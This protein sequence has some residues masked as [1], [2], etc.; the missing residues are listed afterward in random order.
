MITPATIQKRRELALF[1]EAVLAPDP[2]V[3]GVVGIGSIASGLCRPDSDIDAL[4]F[5][6]PF[7]WYVVPAEFK[8]RPSDGSFHSIFSAD[9]AGCIDFDLARCDLAAWSDPAFAWPEGRRA[10][11]ASGW[12]AFDRAGRIAELIADRAAY[13]AALRTARLDEAITWLD[14]HLGE[15]GPQ[16]RWASLGPLIAHDRLQAAYEYLVQ[17]LFAYNRR[18]RAWRNRELPA[19]LELPWLPERFAERLAEAALAPGPDHAGYMRRAAALSG[20]FDDLAGQLHA[21]G[22]YGADVIGEAFIRSHQEPGRAWNMDEW[23]ARH[24]SRRTENP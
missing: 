20:L 19:L 3:Q 23:N 16:V 10:E 17:A 7:D 11:I 12:L 18:W 9:A 22:E 4:V 2:A 24:R 5:L 21:D 15:D 1:I 6:E 13:P 8:W 14:Q